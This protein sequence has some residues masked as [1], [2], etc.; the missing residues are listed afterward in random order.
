VFSNFGRRFNRF[1]IV[2]IFGSVPRISSLMSLC[3][4]GMAGESMN[5]HNTSL[6]AEFIVDKI[7]ARTYSS[8]GLWGLKR[9]V[10][11]VGGITSGRCTPVDLFMII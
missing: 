2:I 9:T 7:I 3:P 5:E 10:N 4:F 8:E 11:P 1:A 6:L